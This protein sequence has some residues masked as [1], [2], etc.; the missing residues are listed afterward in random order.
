MMNQAKMDEN[1]TTVGGLSVLVK[2]NY[3]EIPLV[4]I[5][6][7][8]DSLASIRGQKK[9]GSTYIFTDLRWDF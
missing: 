3:Q 5:E 4:K 8:K 9:V 7:T 2:S 1:N 6:E